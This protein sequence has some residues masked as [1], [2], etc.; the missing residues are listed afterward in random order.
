MTVKGMERTGDNQSLTS[1]V[2]ASIERM[3]VNGELRGGDR[4]NEIALSE[5]FGTSRGP[6]REACRALA[7]EGML[8]AIPNR[9][10]FVRELDLREAL[11]VYDIRA[12]LDELIGALVA[13][14]ITKSELAELQSLIE[15]MDRYA[16]AQDA[17]RYF[18]TNMTFHNMLLALTNN[19]RL[20]R[21]YRGLVKELHL[22]RRKGLIQTNAMRV[23][24]EEHRQVVN[25]IASR[26]PIAAGGA[27][28][29]H[30]LASKQRLIL[31]VKA[32]REQIA[33]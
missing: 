10:V 2:Q 4:V 19:E 3:I 26:D 14:R 22:F 30:V 16:D 18:P 25:A 27:L 6:L 7:Q 17:E 28:K 31:A 1:L 12:T 13:E 24:N 33:S 9:G 20:D 29:C 32:E 15:E 5:K 21:L 11:E 23:S 8:V